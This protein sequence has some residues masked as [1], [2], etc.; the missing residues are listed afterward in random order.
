M[1]GDSGGSNVRYLQ[2]LR[3]HWV[4]IVALAVIAA[5]SAAAYALTATKRYEANADIL[6]SPLPAGNDAFQGF[7]LFRDSS[8][9]SSTVATAA[10]VLRSA[11]I[12]TTA[13]KRLGG[14]GVS[15]PVSP[16][17]QADIVTIG[18]TA[19]DGGLSARAANTY[20]T[21]AVQ[22]RTALFQAEL[23]RRI[24][25]LEAASAS[26]PAS[27]RSG[28]FAYA[29]LQQNLGTLR[30]FVSLGDPTLKILTPASVPASASW[31]R[32]MLSVVVALIAGLLLSGGLA[33]AIEVVNPRIARED[34]LKLGQRLPVLTR[35]PRLP[36]TTVRDYL[37]AGTPLPTE[38]WVGYRTLR[39]MIA[40][41]GPGGAFPR[42]IVVTS[43]TPG[44]GKTM[45]AVNLAITLASSGMR[46]TL[47]DGDFYRPMVGPIFNVIGRTG[48]VIRA[49]DG[50]AA[51]TREALVPV[52]HHPGLQLLLSGR[53]QAERLH[54]LNTGH[55]EALLEK[56]SAQ[57]DVVVFDTP[58]MPEAADALSMA[59]AS[60]VVLV[61]VRLGHTRRDK[62]QQL[63]DLLARRGISPLGFVVTTRQRPQA[64]EYG[65]AAASAQKRTF[66]WISAAR[67]LK[68][69]PLRSHVRTITAV[70]DE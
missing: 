70:D 47:V 16:L 57:S 18:A 21:V 64:G 26:I 52:P 11:D 45:T 44:D 31:P 58:P 28:N 68:D 42:S 12:P 9:G 38:A 35:I 43:A 13:R 49:I 23:H 60:D 29:T 61:A 8:D 41:A 53:E 59:D 50:D 6:I 2:A 56:L 20:A 14:G 1:S 4:M 10:R 7:S 22:K 67:P 66:E 46:V 15:T 19:P 5:L 33:V 62:L 65:Y 32:P 54:M 17:S 36:D 48:G 27:A 40:T 37:S 34:E 55:F 51:A 63:R 30:G 3:A 24:Q 39:A 69:E 25:L